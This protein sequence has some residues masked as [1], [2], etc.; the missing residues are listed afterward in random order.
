MEAV[1]ADITAGPETP[2]RGLAALRFWLRSQIWHRSVFMLPMLAMAYRRRFGQWPRLWQPR[3]FNEKLHLRMALDRRPLL[4]Q[5]AGKLESRAFV[6]QRL[7]RNDM[8]PRLLAAIRHP[9]EVDGLDL[10]PRWIMKASHASGCVRIVT[11]D[12]PIR[13]GEMRRLVAEWLPIEHGRY[14]LEWAYHNVKRVVVVEE[15]LSHQGDVPRDV[16]F[17][18]FHGRVAYIQI[19]SDRF[20]GHQ[21][22]LFD[23]A[24]QRL[25]VQVK[26]YAPHTENVAPPQALSA[27]IRI[28]EQLSAGIDFVR[29]DLYDL[30]ET[31]MVGELTN[32]PQGGSG[33]F[34][35]PHWDDVFG[36]RW[37]LPSLPVLRGW[38]R[39]PHVSGSR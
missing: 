30:G 38:A 6:T 14:G 33:N 16:K 36:E 7:G 27:M 2:R 28:A 12:D 4:T 5:L 21:Q 39:S 25:D 9:D 24:W 8:Q 31:V 11:E 26:N 1:Q 35:P 13:P 34:N 23:T 37:T 3:S 18:C 19:D 20:D 32:Y 15:L 10:P 29:V 17:F 22:S